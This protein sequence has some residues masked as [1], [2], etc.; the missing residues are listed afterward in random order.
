MKTGKEALTISNC[1]LRIAE[2]ATSPR[3]VENSP[4]ILW[5][6]LMARKFPKSRQGRKNRSAV[7]RGTFHPVDAG[8]SHKWLGYCHRVGQTPFAPIVHP[9]LNTGKEALTI[10]NCEL[11]IAERAIRRR[12][13]LADKPVRFGV[14][15]FGVKP[16]GGHAAIRGR[17]CHLN[18]VPVCT[19][20]RDAATSGMVAAF[21]SARGLAHSKTLRVRRAAPHL[22]QVLDCGSPLPLFPRH[23]RAIRVHPCPS[24]VDFVSPQSSISKSL[25]CLFLTIT[26]G[27]GR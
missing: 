3:S 8:P 5:L 9:K 23:H 12:F 16:R 1:E 22:R 7:P 26:N 10:S 21:Q 19:P 18:S 24:V 2:S 4:A 27:P 25:N 6:G 17:K 15:A 20:C 14:A 13:T 11:R